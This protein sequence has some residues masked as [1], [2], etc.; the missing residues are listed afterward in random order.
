MTQ[1]GTLKRGSLEGVPYA[2]VRAPP[3]T[4]IDGSSVQER[5]RGAPLVVGPAPAEKASDAAPYETIPRLLPFEV[6]T[7]KR[8]Q[9]ASGLPAGA[10]AEGPFSSITSE[11]LPADDLPAPDTADTADTLEHADDAPDPAPVAGIPHT[12]FVPQDTPQE[13]QDTPN[14]PNGP[15][16][17]YLI[18]PQRE[19]G[20]QPPAALLRGTARETLAELPLEDPSFDPSVLGSDE[21]VGSSVGT[22]LQLQAVGP[23]NYVLDL[24]AQTTFFKQVY[25]QHTPGASETFDDPFDLV[26]GQSAMVELQRRGDVLGDVYVEVDLPSLG[27]PGG[28]WADAVGY[29]LL[30]RV[31]L[32]VDDV[33]VHDQERLW[34]DMVD[35]LFLAH[36]KRACV[37]GMIGRGRVLAT[38]RAHRIVV[39][40][41]F[42]S[43]SSFGDRPALFPLAALKR[44]SRVRVELAFEG[45]SRCVRLPPGVSVPP[46]AKAPARLLSDQ[47]YVSSIERRALL[48]GRHE[49]MITQ[50]QDADALSYTFDDAGIYDAAAATL[51]L[52]EINLPVKALFLVAYDEAAAD[53]GAMF[54]YLD[55]VEELVLRFGASE[56]FAPRPGTY[57]SLVQTHQHTPRSQ[58]DNVM[59]YSFAR[60]AGL[61]QPSGSMNFAVAEKPALRARLRNT[62][63]RAIKLKVFAH[64]INWVVIDQGSLVMRYT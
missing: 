48:H 29:A 8:A 42:S 28:R 53:K 27:V 3:D 52:R 38:D 55:C 17:P 25:S 47:V 7:S 63:G 1:R 32:W 15:K 64:C 60:D 24:N 45:L 11:A 35:R 26:F 23:Q 30:S 16:V 43:C 61:A 21:R 36:G 62:G 57:F 39:P 13:V 18:D 59:C 40:L 37:D 19:P 51:D 20:F 58:A 31:R 50:Q 44:T 33:V 41:K 2:D 34:Y 14:V 46:L 6:P 9:V 4:P 22:W 56:R 54:D 10:A 5:L 12:A 49:I